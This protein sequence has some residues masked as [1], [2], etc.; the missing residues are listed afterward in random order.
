MQL[1]ALKSDYS[2]CAILNPVNVQ[3]N[4]K[5]YE[6]GSFSVQ[7][8]AKDYLS[9]M[10][11]IYFS[12][13]N[14]TGMIQDKV[15]SENVKGKY[16]QIS[17]FFL[18]KELDDKI[19]Y[20][21]FYAS[22]NTET[23]IRQMVNSYREDIPLLELDSTDNQ[24]GGSVDFQNTAGNLGTV[25]YSVLKTKE[26]SQRV[27]YDYTT[28]KK[29]YSVWQGV[30]RTRSQTTNN[31]I[32]FS[33]NFGNI[34][35]PSVEVD[36]SNFKNYAL[37]GGSG[38]GADRI[39]QVV[40]LSSGSYKKKIFIDAKDETYDTKTQT[41][42]E[43]K[44]NLY[45]RGVEKLLNYQTINNITFDSSN[46][47]Y[48]YLTDYDLGDKCDVLIDSLQLALECRIIAIYEVFKENKH[49]IE[50]EFGEKK[51]TNYEKARL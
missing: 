45:Q 34:K 41:L 47:S 32:T 29:K 3:W 25:A 35:N 44:N 7:L 30:D 42:A 36:T 6:S 38:D 39:Y 51:L 11:F 10:S 18:E 31:F 40:D 33:S 37:V 26:L 5:Y 16:I 46:S 27:I 21:T 22:G 17:G 20:P 13:R 2:I 19:V 48:V 15:Y 43:Y 28:N 50:L 4:R 12:E 14:E 8:H 23:K 49:T 24:K 1:M 9:E